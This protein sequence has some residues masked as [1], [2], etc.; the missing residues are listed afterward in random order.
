MSYFSSESRIV[1][2]QK[3]NF[4]VR[5]RIT[6]INKSQS[7]NWAAIVYKDWILQSHNL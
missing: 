5:I 1:F 7:S 6:E 4:P 3:S 2:E